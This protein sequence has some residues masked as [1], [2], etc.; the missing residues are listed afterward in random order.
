MSAALAHIRSKVGAGS[1]AESCKRK[2][3]RVDMDG[4][5]ACRVIVDMDKIAAARSAEG[6]RC[7]FVLFLS[8]ERGKLIVA[9]IELKSGYVD[10]SEAA[11]QLC[12][13]TGFADRASPAKTKLC[14][15]PILFHGKGIDPLQR[16]ALNRSKITFRGTKLTIKTAR[17]GRPRDLAGALGV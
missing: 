13:G 4:I 5:P 14:C 11:E 12:S 16:R 17:C 10:G 6:K 15:Q 7:D 2:G 8:Q 3:C 9:P 1:L